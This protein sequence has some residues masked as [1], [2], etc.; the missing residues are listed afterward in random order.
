LSD[1]T[2]LAPPVLDPAQLIRIEAVHRGFLYQHLY[3]AHCLLLAAATDVRSIV[4]ESDEDVEIVRL[5]LRTYVQVKH[6]ASSLSFR[7]IE[8]A[9]ERFTALRALHATQAVRQG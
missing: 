4:V 7:D 1:S 2:P 8:D 9:L 3:V 5:S 6:R